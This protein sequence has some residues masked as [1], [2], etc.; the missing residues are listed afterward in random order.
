MQI[1]L[2]GLSLA[3]NLVK[4][5]LSLYGTEW[6][7]RGYG[8]CNNGIVGMSSLSFSSVDLSLTELK[9][10]YRV[11]TMPST[12]LAFNYCVQPGPAMLADL[13]I[14]WATFVITI[15]VTKFA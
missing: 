2:L 10:N 3:G 11:P 1:G 7:E 12:E 15:E 14:L 4:P 9:K 5:L 6:R 13:F 8:L